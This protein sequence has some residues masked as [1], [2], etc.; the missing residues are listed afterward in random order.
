MSTK[1]PLSLCV[2]SGILTYFNGSREGPKS[3]MLGIN[4]YSE[5]L[6]I[7]TAT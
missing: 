6:V 2:F 3:R 1:L 7:A 4:C 5:K